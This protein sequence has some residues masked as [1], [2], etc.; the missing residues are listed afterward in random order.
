MTMTA[1]AGPLGTDAAAAAA[2]M[3][4]RDMEFGRVAIVLRAALPGVEA[5]S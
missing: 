2:I 4:H 3:A 5:E 1:T